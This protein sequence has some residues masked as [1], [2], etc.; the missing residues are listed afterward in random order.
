M[1]YPKDKYLIPIFVPAIVLAV[2]ALNNEPLSR[3]VMR[4]WFW[5]EFIAGTMVAGIIW[6][7][8]RFISVRLDKKAEWKKRFNRRLL[9]Q[10]FFG[11]AIPSAIL[12]FLCWMMFEWIIGQPMFDTLF[13]Y[14]EFPFS[15]LV[16]AGIN[17]YYLIYKLLESETVETI[18]EEIQPGITQ[19]TLFAYKGADRF[20]LHHGMINIVVKNTAYL[21]VYTS[22]GKRLNMTGTLDSLEKLLPDDTFF[23][24]NR[25]VIMHIKSIQSFRSIEHGKIEINCGLASIESPI[26][27]QKKAADFRKWM[28]KKV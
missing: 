4:D 2:E 7:S 5:K 13:P 14:Y 15:M 24:V 23:R 8:V 17:G 28:Q 21:D 25:Q 10:V 11:W 26:V 1:Q 22:D 3:L 18:T 16:I 9:L 6:L 27:S 20:P 12:F 19:I